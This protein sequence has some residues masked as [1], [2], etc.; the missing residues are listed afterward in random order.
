ME[1]DAQYH[2]RLRCG[3]T[4]SERFKRVG[5]ACPA[6]C[7]CA[8]KILTGGLYEPLF[9][10]GNGTK[11][12]RIDFPWNGSPED[13]DAVR[14]AVDAHAVFR[15]HCGLFEPEDCSVVRFFNVNKS[16]AASDIL[17]CFELLHTSFSLL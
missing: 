15:V 17:K 5:C 8:G 10:S 6:G 12:F 3:I 1:P 14:Q 7:G 16:V 2:E 13:G 9:E 4:D 11:G